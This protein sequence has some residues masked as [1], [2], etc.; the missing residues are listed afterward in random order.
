M[1]KERITSVIL[2]ILLSVFCIIPIFEFKLHVNEKP[3]DLYRVYLNG[4]SIG[5]IKS[6][7]RLQNYINEEQKELPE[8]STTL[9][10]DGRVL[11]QN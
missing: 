1:N 9:N 2:T 5:T 3:M 6:R 4:K 8:M 11:K 7:E 10:W